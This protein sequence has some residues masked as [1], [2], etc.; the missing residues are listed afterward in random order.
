LN[1][2]IIA[3]EAITIATTTGATGIGT[4]TGL[5]TGMTA[6]W[7]NNTIKISGTPTVA[8]TF[9]YTIPLTGGCGIVNATG[10]I[11]VTDCRQLFVGNNPNSSQI[12]VVGTLIE[13]FIV[14]TENATSIIPFFLPPGV[15]A[16]LEDNI[17]KISGTPTSTGQYLFQINVIGDCGQ[18]RAVSGIITVNSQP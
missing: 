10:T 8:S 17:L 14:D 16:I 15:T 18:I 3:Q 4:A 11:S 7:S 9:N 1:T 13:P 12:V 6:T 2:T 5:P